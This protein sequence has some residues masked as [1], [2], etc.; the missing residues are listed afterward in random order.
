M[1]CPLRRKCGNHATPLALHLNARIAAQCAAK[2]KLVAIASIVLKIA[3]VHA[4]DD[5]QAI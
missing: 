3:H 4:Q 1:H 5:T 2:K